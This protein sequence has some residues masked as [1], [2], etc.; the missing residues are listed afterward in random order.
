MIG[1]NTYM[2][3]IFKSGPIYINI[4]RDYSAYKTNFEEYRL[5]NRS[6]LTLEIKIGRCIYMRAI[7]QS[8]RIS[9][10][11]RTVYS[12]YSKKYTKNFLEGRMITMSY[13]K[14]IPQ[15]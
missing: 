8:K 2:G 13:V 5:I 10:R 3:T 4:R 7:S 1:R 14:L 12:M 6:S 9:I 11:L 15:I